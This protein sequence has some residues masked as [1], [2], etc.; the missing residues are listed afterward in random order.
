MLRI[1]SID[2][3]SAA[4]YRLSTP[5]FD[6]SL[7]FETPARV[8]ELVA[9]GHCDAALLPVASIPVAGDRIN[10]LGSYGI[11]C[12]GAV[13]SVQLFSEIPLE[14]LLRDRLPIY[15]TPKSRTSVALLELLCWHQY[16]VSPVLTKSYPDAMAH[17]LIG[18]AAFECAHT[19]SNSG[20]CVDLSAWWHAQTGF[21]FV[22]ARWVVS[23]SLE[24]LDR[25]RLL[26]WL[27]CCVMRAASPE[28]I[29]ILSSSRGDANTY[30]GYYKRLRTRLGED[31]LAGLHHF[32]QL[33][34]STS[35]GTTA[36][37]A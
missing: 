17:L 28:G 6:H 25:A 1:V 26:A 21:P 7:R 36:L 13:R 33:M 29:E 32:L 12:R 20:H 3:L 30:Q 4:P 27:E 8:H 14:T 22:F 18:D 5:D 2:N 9:D 11:A 19:K 16:G 31:D 23:S 37:I 10:T 24:E 34:E 35:Y 15:A